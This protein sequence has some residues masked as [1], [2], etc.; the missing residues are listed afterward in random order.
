MGMTNVNQITDANVILGISEAFLVKA[1]LYL[2]ISDAQLG[3]SSLTLKSSLTNCTMK[4]MVF[5]LREL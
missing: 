5:N 2:I 1:I 4:M 3:K